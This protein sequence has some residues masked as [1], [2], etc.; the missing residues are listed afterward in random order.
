MY[1]MKGLAVLWQLNTGHFSLNYALWRFPPYPIHMAQI[2]NCCEPCTLGRKRSVTNLLSRKSWP[3]KRFCV[4]TRF[5]LFAQWIRYWPVNHF[6]WIVV[7]KCFVSMVGM[8]K[9][10]NTVM[11]PGLRLSRLAV[12]DINWQV[13]CWLVMR[14]KSNLVWSRIRHKL[15]RSC[16]LF[17]LPHRNRHSWLP[18]L[19]FEN[20]DGLSV[21][22][23]ISLKWMF[24]ALSRQSWTLFHFS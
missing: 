14:E 4:H 23:V 18:W 13:Y 5:V 19:S 24:E 17:A 20:T 22:Q 10:A 16:E 11:S 12:S 8:H 9:V 15:L 6:E 3:V 1:A 7:I 21:H 2:G